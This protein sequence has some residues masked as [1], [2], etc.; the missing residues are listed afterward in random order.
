MNGMLQTC[1][2]VHIPKEWILLDSQSTI[3]IFSNCHLLKNIHKSDGWIHIHCNAGI[4]RKNLVGDFSGYGTV[5]YHPDGIANILSLAEVCRQFHVTYDSSKH[6]EFIIHKPDG[7]TKQFI[8]S[9][10]GLYYLNTSTKC[11]MLID[12]VDNNKSKYSNTDYSHA[13]LVCRI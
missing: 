10:R 8:Q 13:Q 3:S 1:H 7:S 6:N 12:T 11:V 9:E 4:T 2:G 5:W